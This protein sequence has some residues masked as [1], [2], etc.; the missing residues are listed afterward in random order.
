MLLPGL[1]LIGTIC[2]QGVLLDN[3]SNFTLHLLKLSAGVDL[4]FQVLCLAHFDRVRIITPSP[5]GGDWVYRK[6]KEMA[7]QNR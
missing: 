1:G 6:T 5:I 3:T 2:L 7:I 4:G